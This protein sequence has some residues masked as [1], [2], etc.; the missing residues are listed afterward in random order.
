MVESRKSQFKKV[1]LPYYRPWIVLITDGNPDPFNE[2]E[3]NHI[4]SKIRY[5]IQNK[6]FIFDA[7]GIGKKVDTN[8][9][10]FISSDNYKR[11]SRRNF[12]TMF[13]TLSCSLNSISKGFDTDN[14]L[15]GLDD[16][17]L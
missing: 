16:I 4:A 17:D 15:D 5:G 9:L 14:P 12:S 13:Q 2:H 6:K 1:G 10:K 3:I 7:I 8:F 11:I